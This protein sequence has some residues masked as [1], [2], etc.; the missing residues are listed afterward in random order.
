MMRAK[1]FLIASVCAALFAAAGVQAA[2]PKPPRATLGTTVTLPVTAS[3]EVANDQAVIE[4]YVLEQ[5][6]D[7]AQAT[8]KAIERAAEGLKQLKA[9]YPQ[10]ELKNQTLTST[11]R[12]SK[13]KEGEAPEIVGWEVRQSVSAKLKNVEQAAPFVQSA[14]KYFA[15][16][17]VGFQLSPESRAAV[18]DQLVREAIKNMKAQAKVIAEAMVGQNARVTYETVDFHNAAYD[19]PVTYRMNADMVMAK[20]MAAEAA[21]ALPVF[22]P[23]M[24]TLSRNLTAKVRIL[25]KAKAR[26]KAPKPDNDRPRPM[27]P[28]ANV[29]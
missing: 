7:I 1:S 28:I 19:R 16:S 20:A 13:A 10:A 26:V 25:P 3:V 18:Q 22:E 11:P 21:P 6:K 29:N 8:T 4:L 23:G 2:A 17:S 27:H 12:Y 15:F 9:L 14:Q 5:S 24:T